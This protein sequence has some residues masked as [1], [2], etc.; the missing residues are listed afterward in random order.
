MRRESEITN[1]KRKWGG[2][3]EDSLPSL[4]ANRKIEWILIKVVY[5]DSNLSCD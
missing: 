1:T 3:L 2:R 5:Q 4:H